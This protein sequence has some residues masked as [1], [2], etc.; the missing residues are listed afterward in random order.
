[1]ALLLAFGQTKIQV[2]FR[3]LWVTHPAVHAVASCAGREAARAGTEPLIY[4]LYPVAG[5]AKG[6]AFAT[7][8]TAT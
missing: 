5:R 4:S 6:F 1:M 2:A 8:A 7:E 3:Q